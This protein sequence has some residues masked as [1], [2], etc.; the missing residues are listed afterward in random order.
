MKIG[1]DFEYNDYK[2]KIDIS[3]KDYI[4]KKFLSY[5][6]FFSGRAAIY[7][8]IKSIIDKEKIDNIY[9]PSYICESI[10]LP[11]Y[12]AIM[13]SKIKLFFYKQ[14]LDL[15]SPGIEIQE[16]SIVYIVD[17]FGKI[18][19]PLLRY[20]NSYKIKFSKVFI[21]RDITHSLF[22]KNFFLEPD[23]Y[24]CSLRKWLFLPDGAFVSSNTNKI[25]FP[26]IKANDDIVQARISAAILKR[27]SQKFC[28]APFEDKIYLNIWKF[29]ES[30]FN[31][32]LYNVSI[33]D[34]SNKL[35]ENADYQQIENRRKANG[36]YLLD[37]L[38]DFEEFSVI[39]NDTFIFNISVLFNS[40]K[41]RDIFRR[42]MMNEFNIYLPIHWP[43]EWQDSIEY[44][45]KDS[46]KQN[47]I[48]SNKILSFVID[49][50]YGKK[51]MDYILS[52]CKKALGKLR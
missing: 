28:G 2:K 47:K 34:F 10:Y 22:N 35:L 44:I 17:Y 51:E 4:S 12:R 32:Y 18:D 38:H 39:P 7:S 27:L 31:D 8:L 21:I 20:L 11:I 49:Q 15:S 36:K 1:G 52:S 25:K 45:D 30:K 33:S 13:T 5:Q 43:M 46:L 26:L 40:M 50:R 3:L 16:N 6:L 37:R 14:N 48:I 23:Y 42:N 41:I 29:C 24:I 9:I 19:L